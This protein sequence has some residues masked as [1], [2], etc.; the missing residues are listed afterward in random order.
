MTLVKNE[1]RNVIFLKVSDVFF[2]L[3]RPIF[4]EIMTFDQNISAKIS[5]IV[6]GSFKIL[7]LAKMKDRNLI[8]LEV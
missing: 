2:G 8:F 7:A 6:S 1:N 3:S 5:K 4:P